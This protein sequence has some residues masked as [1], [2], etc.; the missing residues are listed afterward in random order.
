MSTSKIGAVPFERMRAI[1]LSSAKVA[2]LVGALPHDPLPGWLN[3]LRDS[4]AE[5][6]YA[7]PA[8]SACD[9]VEAAE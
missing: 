9:R 2:T 1:G 5:D 6:I 4:F 8:L 7:L 3:R